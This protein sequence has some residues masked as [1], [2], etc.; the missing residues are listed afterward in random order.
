MMAVG[1]LMQS[2]RHIDRLWAAGSWEKVLRLL[3]QRAPTI[4]Y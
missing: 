3:K 4:R 2:E 1:C